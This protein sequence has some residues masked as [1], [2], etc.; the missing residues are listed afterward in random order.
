MSNL[1]V[2]PMVIPLMVGIICI[3][4]KPF[5]KLQRILS[6]LALVVTAGVGIYMLQIVKNEGIM[7]LD[8]GGWKPPYGILFVADSFALLL[9]VTASIVSVACLLY[10]FASIGE[11]R[12]KMYFYPL[13]LLLIAGVNGSFLT[14]DLFNLFVCIEVML[15]A[16][17]T[18]LSLGG[19]KGQLKATVPYVI[20]NVLSSWFFLVAIGF[21]YGKVGTLNMAHLAERIG[22]M[23]GEPI[24]I[25][26]GLVFLLVFSLKAGLVLYFWLPRSYSAPPTAISALFAAL[27]TKVGIY[28]IF[29]MF[30]LVFASE[31]STFQPIILTMA[32]ITLIGGVLGAVA[33][34]DIRQIGAYNVVIAVGFII[35]GLGLFTEASLQGSIYYLIHDMIAKG[36][37]FLLIGT[38]VTVAGT[39]K[40]DRMSGLIVNYPVLGWL[41]F[42][43]MLALAGFPPLSGFIGKVLMGQGAIESGSYIMLA[44]LF[45]SSLFVLYSLLRIFLSCFWGETIMSERKEVPLK[46]SW[47]ASCLMLAFLIIAL[48]LGAETIAD[49][50]T[51]AAHTLLNPEVYI[52]AVLEK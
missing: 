31:F 9:V 12:E 32:V 3:F 27:L 24:L 18:L 5:L 52:S 38:V 17:Y 29:R 37:L 51:D 26:I 23:S 50:V 16:S 7:R 2:L 4:F 15:L 43:V 21:L 42:I 47:L 28:A 36:L 49:Y 39:A 35:A 40:M 46:K 48:G 34:T 45:L 8:F 1:V 33:Y 25:V 30:T 10:A 13:V 41:F 11:A 6:L 44:I 22:E 14:G 19:L 20:I